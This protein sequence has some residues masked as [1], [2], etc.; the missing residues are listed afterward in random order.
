MSGRA[1]ARNLLSRSTPSVEFRKHLHMD[2]RL[3]IIEKAALATIIVSLL[4][5]A[6]VLFA[7]WV[8]P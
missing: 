6:S 8:T 1:E 2:R 4:V 5:I 3:S 7:L